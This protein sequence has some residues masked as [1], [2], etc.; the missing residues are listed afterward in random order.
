MTP[1]AG[2]PASLHGH[3]DPSPETC[4]AS[5]RSLPPA[6]PLTTVPC[7]PVTPG[8]DPAP[9]LLS[10]P[11]AVPLTLTALLPTPR[12]ARASSC[13]C[14]FTPRGLCPSSFPGVSSCVWIL[15]CMALTWSLGPGLRR[16][17]QSMLA[18]REAPGLLVSRSCLSQR[19]DGERVCDVCVPGFARWTRGE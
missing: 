10:L 6:H 4:W 8:L 14:P 2:A 11:T 17:A 5:S 7:F 9:E 13:F 12:P 15:A 3:T 16:P 18:A 19:G 1:P